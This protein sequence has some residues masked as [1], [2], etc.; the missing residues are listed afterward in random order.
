[1]LS[2]SGQLQFV[3]AIGYIWALETGYV[4][5]GFCHEYIDINTNLMDCTSSVIIFTVY[6][7]K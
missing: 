7:F 2:G 1:M 5:M 4:F 6:Y 3:K